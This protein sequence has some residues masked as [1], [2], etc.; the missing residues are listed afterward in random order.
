MD[1][2]FSK[3][4]GIA[5]TP[6]N[7]PE[8]PS[9]PFLTEGVII[10]PKA[11][12]PV[13]GNSEDERAINI[14]QRQADINGA[15]KERALTVCRTYQQNLI[16]VSQMQAEIL[17]GA[18]AGADIYDL[19]LKAVKALSFLTN[20][21]VIYGEAERDVRAVYGIG[22]SEAAP[23][24]AELEEVEARLSKLREAEETTSGDE[25]KRIQN[26]IAEHEKR[27]AALKRALEK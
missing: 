19:F 15:E 3:L 1:I 20:D 4:D 27:A 9:E 26:A 23:L 13:Q 10:P 16:A 5:Y 6:R 25:L 21:N 12:N 24:S 18:A 22:L 17:K 8:S 2:D 11:E 7:A 14:L